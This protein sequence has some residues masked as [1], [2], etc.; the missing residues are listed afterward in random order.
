MARRPQ[1][2]FSRIERVWL[3][4]PIKT[5]FLNALSVLIPTSERAV[6]DIMRNQL[7]RIHDPI[8]K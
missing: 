4:D 3:A 1:F 6:N 7:K 5:H 2:N 8:L